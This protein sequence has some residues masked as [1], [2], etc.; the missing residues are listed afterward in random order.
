MPLHQ[1]GK[2][3]KQ[4]QFPEY[5]KYQRGKAWYIA[6]GI[7]GGGLFLFGLLTN[8]FLFSIIIVMVGLIAL[9][10]E[11]R[12]PLTMTFQI[13]TRGIKLNDRFYPYTDIESFWLAYDPP[14]VKKIYFLLKNIFH[15]VLV[16]PFDKESPLD[17]R[18]LLGKYLEEDLDKE[19]ETTAEAL[20]RFIKI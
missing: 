10:S 4:W 9:N 17:L 19:G 18:E 5:V 14:E 2:I 12:E 15:Q 11:K 3:I 13:T 16:I 1:E 7:I 20:G 6:A 8:D